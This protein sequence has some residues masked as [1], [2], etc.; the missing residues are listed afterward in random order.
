MPKPC[1][2][3]LGLPDPTGKDNEAFGSV[4]QTVEAEILK[5]AETLKL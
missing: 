5:L 1:R 2:E 4:I 3:D